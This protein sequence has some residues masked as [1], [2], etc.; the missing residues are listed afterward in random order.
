MTQWIVLC[1][2][3]SLDMFCVKVFFFV[4]KCLTLFYRYYNLI[5]RIMKRMKFVE[6]VPPE[7]DVLSYHNES[8]FA[9][10]PNLENPNEGDE[11]GWD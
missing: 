5:I 7:V 9:T 11:Y 3:A 10:S 2:A 4:V 8:G 6:Y 1:G